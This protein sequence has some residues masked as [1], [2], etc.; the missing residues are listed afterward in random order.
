M[1]RAQASGD[2]LL[3]SEHNHMF[4]GSDSTNASAVPATTID[5]FHSGLQAAANYRAAHP[6]FL[7]LYG[8]EWGV[9]STAAISTSSTAMR[10]RSGSSTI[11]AS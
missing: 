1:M 5:L 10:W 4:D 7:A 2:F 8:L 11:P 6:G 3:T 9:I